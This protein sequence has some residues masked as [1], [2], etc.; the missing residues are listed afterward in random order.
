MASQM[1]AARNARAPQNLSATGGLEKL[2]WR[3]WTRLREHGSSTYGL[4]GRRRALWSL[5]GAVAG[6]DP[7]RAPRS[8]FAGSLR[9]HTHVSLVFLRRAGAFSRLVSSDR[10]SRPYRIPAL[11]CDRH[12]L[13]VI[14]HHPDREHPA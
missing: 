1:R 13:V 14:V 11:G 10:C 7:D 6:S 4:Q 12:D 5:A 8:A 9:R 2:A 3:S